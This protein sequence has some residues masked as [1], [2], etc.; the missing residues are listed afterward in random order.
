[1][2]EPKIVSE[3]CGVEYVRKE[4][5]SFREMMG[6]KKYW[7]FADETRFLRKIDLAFKGLFHIY[8]LAKDLTDMDR[9]HM[10][11]IIIEFEKRRLY[12]DFMPTKVKEEKNANRT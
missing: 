1:M 11:A 10:E 6:S 2:S 3:C 9:V 8:A 7:E 4:M 5:L 12:M